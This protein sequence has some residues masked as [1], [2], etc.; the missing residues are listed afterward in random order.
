MSLTNDKTA[1]RYNI[2]YA[3]PPWKFSPMGISPDKI[4]GD[5]YK[6]RQAESHY[7]TMSIED[8]AKLP[9]KSLAAKSSVIFMWVTSPFLEKGIEVMKAWGFK[10]KTV[11]FCWAKRNKDD[12]RWASGM[13][14]YTLSQVELCLIGTKGP[15]LKRIKRN[16]RQLIVAP[17][18]KHSSKPHTARERIEAIYGDVPRIELFARERTPGWDAFGNEVES[19]VSLVGD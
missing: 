13:G 14:W 19:D 11:G 7:Q 16:V 4:H 2:I 15:T 5:N 18:G 17:R 1:T 9:V 10:Y 6:S 3:D 8:I 12:T